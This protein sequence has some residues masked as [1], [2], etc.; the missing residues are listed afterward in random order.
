M[1]KH[2]TPSSTEIHFAPHTKQILPKFPVQQKGQYYRL[3]QKQTMSRFCNERT[4]LHPLRKRSGLK[5]KF[6]GF[7]QF[8]QATAGTAGLP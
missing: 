7:L 1:L 3:E 5:G 2:A 8:L 4:R 6:R